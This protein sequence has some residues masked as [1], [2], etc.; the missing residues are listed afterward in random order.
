MGFFFNAGET[1][2]RAGV[3]QR[4]E[5]VGGAQGAGAVDGICAATFRGNWGNT[6]EVMTFMSAEDVA[7]QLGDGGKNSTVNLLKELFTGGATTVH[8]VR[9]GA[10]GAKATATIT[11]T[12]VAPPKKVLENV[13]AAFIPAIAGDGGDTFDY[14]AFKTHYREV[15][16]DY[17]GDAASFASLD[18]IQQDK[19]QITVA[20]AKAVFINLPWVA[21]RFDNTEPLQRLSISYTKDGAPGTFV[22]GNGETGVNTK[23]VI[24]GSEPIR[25]GSRMA[26]YVLGDGA[27]ETDANLGLTGDAANGTYSFIVTGV[28][29]GGESVTV[30]ADPVTYGAATA[31]ASAPRAAA[32]HNAALILTAKSAGS[33][34]LRYS[35]RE[36]LGDSASREF[37]VVEGSRTMEKITFPASESGEVE[38]LNAAINRQS[39]FFTSEI[40]AGYA[41]TGK[42]Q[43]VAETSMTP[44]ADPVV[45]NADYSDAFV[46]LEGYRW[47][48]VSVDT[49]DVGVH[50]MLAAYMNRVY[51]EGK[52]AFAVVGEPTSVPLDDRMAH[53]AAYNDYNVIYVGS[54]GLD[55]AGAAVEGKQ[56]VARVA[57]MVAAVPSSQSL[58]HRPVPGL[59][60]PLEMLTNAKYEKA[61]NSGMLAFSTSSAGTV[62]IE[63]GITTLVNPSGEDDA[64]WKKIKRAKIRFE[65]MNRCSDTVEPLIGQ[66]NNNTD[67]RANIISIIQ[68]QVLDR[69]VNEGKLEAGAQII[70]D[71][72]NAPQG[73]SAWFVIT[74]DDTDSMEKIYLNFQFRFS[75]AV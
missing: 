32:A 71:P 22:K 63:Q 29:V 15:M 7:A 40:V 64:G 58:T 52:M 65:L 33:R 54:G 4:Y 47:N 19:G 60:K 31:A 24:S 68:G 26:S 11:D 10:G 59:V 34:A 42:L 6:G 21:V 48:T 70:V 56:I 9:L 28:T 38:A 2:A 75:A 20:E 74:A 50:A 25:A 35:I 69:M 16:G 72:N 41:G 37:V 14:E 53:A 27:I 3:Y 18:K 17:D 46:L 67:G 8:A 43:I 12:S 49:D 45:T 30:T 1:K 23:D 5:N 44:G 51:N 13:R 55:A 36:V 39:A 62:W 57:G 73:D 61:V 66:I